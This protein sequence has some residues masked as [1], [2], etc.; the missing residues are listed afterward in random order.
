MKKLKNYTLQPNAVFDLDLLP[1]SMLII[2]YLNS[3]GKNWNVFKEEVRKHLH[4]GHTRHNNAW[5]QLIR[6]KILIKNKGFG[7][8]NFVLN[9]DVIDAL[10]TNDNVTNDNV[11]NENVTYDNVTYVSVR[12][13]NTDGV[14]ITDVGENNDRVTN[15]NML[16]PEQVLIVTGSESFKI[17]RKQIS[18][19]TPETFLH[20]KSQVTK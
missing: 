16:T 17:A 20:Y 19:L 3:R 9:A 18:S 1:E 8:C 10:V 7:K 11:T 15:T 14:T 12:G 13:T 6:K 2:L 4:L 5:K